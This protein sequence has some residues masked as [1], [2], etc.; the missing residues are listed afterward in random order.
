MRTRFGSASTTNTSDTLDNDKRPTMP[1]T[2]PQAEASPFIGLALTFKSIN[3]E[4]RTADFVA[5]TDA[6]DSYDEIVDQSSWELD[7]YKSNPVVLFA[8]KSRDLPI[9]KST[10]VQVRN[11]RLECTIEFAPESANPEAE[12]VWQL[13]QGEY[14]RAVSVGF[15][16]RDYRWEKRDGNEVIVL[17]GNSLREISVTPVPANHEAL[18][19]MRARAMAEKATNGPRTPATLPESGPETHMDEATKK[20]LETKD[21][22]LKDVSEKLATASKAIEAIGLEAKADKEALEVKTA[23]LAALE[24]KAKAALGA[25][26]DETLAD[27]CARVVAEK[28]ALVDSL[29]EKDVDALVGKKLVPAQKAEFLSLA[30]KDRE[31]FD[32]IVKNLPDLNLTTPV[33][34]AT[35]GVSDVPDLS[36]LVG[37]PGSAGEGSDLSAFLD[38]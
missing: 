1:D 15:I 14:L 17:Y 3:V 7:I 5:S 12:R 2:T 24:A 31:L 9:G 27:A 35:K 20:A 33:V 16:P 38:D 28:A 32:G 23:E 30:K 34:D 6:V 25:T 8:H 4:A 10:D 22:E 36:S 37:E 21:A 19:K 13:V 29:I 26:K 11:G 18:A